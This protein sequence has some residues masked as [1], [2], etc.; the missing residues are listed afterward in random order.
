MGFKDVKLVVG[1]LLLRHKL[2]PFRLA[3]KDEIYQL[4]DS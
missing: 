2:L 4:K 1:R 3:L